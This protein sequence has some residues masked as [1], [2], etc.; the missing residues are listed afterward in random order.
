MEHGFT[1]K[2]KY[3]RLQIERRWRDGDSCDTPA[4]NTGNELLIPLYYKWLSFDGDCV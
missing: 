3:W 1:A 2:A 4:D